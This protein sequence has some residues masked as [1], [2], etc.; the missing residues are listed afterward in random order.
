MI[1]QKVVLEVTVGDRSYSMECYHDS[2]LGEIHDALSQMKAFVIQKM[3]DAEQVKD[4]P[5]IE[6]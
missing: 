6:G 3:K 1:K 2:P 4:S 5:A